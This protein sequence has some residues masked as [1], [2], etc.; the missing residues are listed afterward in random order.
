MRPGLSSAQ[1]LK[2]L[3]TFMQVARK[4]GIDQIREGRP[5]T[6]WEQQTRNALR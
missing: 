3:D 4:K 5:L 6:S 1:K 2:L